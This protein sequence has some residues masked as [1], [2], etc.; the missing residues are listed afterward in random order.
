MATTH[1]A[2]RHHSVLVLLAGAA[3]TLPA[4]PL[5]A[6]KSESPAGQQLAAFHRDVAWQRFLDQ[7]GGTW[8]VEWCPATGTPKA[9]WGSGAPLA[10]WRENSLAEARRHAV[11]LL[12]DRADLLR[13][14]ASDFREVI[15]ARMGRTWVFVFDQYFRGLPVVGGRADVRVHMVGRVPMFGSTA[16]QIPTDFDIVPRFD[17]DTALALAWQALA[18]APTGARQPAAVAPPRLVIWGDVDATAPAPFHLAWEVAIS[19][20]DAAGKGPIGRYYIE[21]RT[22]AVLHYTNDKHECG[23]ADCPHGAG[24]AQPAAAAPTAPLPV[25]TTVTVRGWTRTG[26]DGYDPL[27]NVPLPGVQLSVPGIGTV[28]TDQNGQFAIDIAAPVSID[29]TA[30][31]GRHHAAIAGSDAPSGSFLVNPG[32][33]TTIQL[34]TAGASQAA[35]AHTTTSWWLDKTNEFCRGILGNTAQLNTASNVVPTVN[36][37]DTCNAYYTGNTVNFFLAGGSCNNTAFST[38]IAHEWGHGLDD[39]YGGISQTNGLSEGWGDIIGLYLVDSPILGSGFS[40]AGVGIRNGNNT[41]Q[42]PASG[43][44]HTQGQSWMGFAWKLRDRMATTLGSRSTAIAVTNDIV[45]GSIVADAVN[46]ADAAFEVFVADDDDGNLANQT[47]HWDDLVW[48]CGQHSLPYPNAP[49]NVPNDQCTA[50]I[51]LVNGINGP[52][53]TVGATTSTPTWSCGSGANDVWFTYST[54]AS[55]TLVVETCSQAAWD[56]ALQVFSGSCASLTSVACNDD[57]CSLQSRVSV[58]IAPG[59]YFIRVGGYNG[60][61]GTFSLNVSGPGGILASSTPFGPG[62]YRL[63]KAYYESFASAAFDLGGTAMRLARTDGYYVAQPGGAYV[64]PSGSAQVLSLSDDGAASVALGGTFSYPGGTTTSLEVCAN[65]FVSVAAGNG[66]AYTPSAAGWLGSAQPRWGTWHDFN[67]SATGSG[68]VK[69]ERVGQVA[70]VTWDGVYSYGTTAA[71]TWQLQFDLATGDVT[72]VWQTMVASGNGWLVGHAGAAPNDDLGSLDISAAL[73]GTFRTGPENTQPLQLSSTLPVLG[74]TL[75]LTT[76]Q[77]PP[78]SLLGVQILSLVRY[79]PGVDLAVV[80]MPGCVLHANLDL[81]AALFP[82]AGQATYGWQVPNDPGSLGLQLTAQ[83]AAFVTGLNA[84]G[85]NASNGVALT[86]GF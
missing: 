81:L 16:W 74:T 20:V 67:P 9:I 77:F 37:A 61:T 82:V 22:G 54:G 84:F 71:N 30:L 28:T 58:G 29:V 2:T 41:V 63:S 31:D 42:Y 17:G 79:D 36:I 62:C 72:Y 34:L 56:T 75:T 80:G 85:M 83:S 70:Y 4:T 19:N 86:V 78:S 73:P 43:G 40:T 33:A 48:A 6:Q 46:Q 8:R 35:A 64:A 51:P 24:W 5:P 38:V 66:T 65:G 50:A 59:T 55:G 11:Q 12:Q 1:P 76:A 27:V 44:V 60:A 13:L 21:A 7:D 32:V 26:N 39:R 68:K 23:R 69:F 25:M 52:F 47:P 49:G 14:G 10:D 15:G 3:L 45:I 18:Q 57:T 53:T